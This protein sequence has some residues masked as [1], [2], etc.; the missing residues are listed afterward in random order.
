V[1]YKKGTKKRGRN[2]SLQ[3]RRVRESL[4]AVQDERT[5]RRSVEGKNEASGGGGRGKRKVL[6]E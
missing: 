4:S 5:G 6:R 2:G 1:T 3:S